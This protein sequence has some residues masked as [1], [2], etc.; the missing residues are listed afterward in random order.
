MEDVSMSGF[1]SAG[2]CAR[3]ENPLV[4]KIRKPVIS[5]TRNFRICVSNP[6]L[7]KYNGLG[8]LGIHFV[9]P[10]AR[11]L[12]RDHISDYNISDYG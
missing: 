11:G 7:G 12:L 6:Q 9:A 1:F 10:D 4:N 5:K 2:C 8:R 3:A